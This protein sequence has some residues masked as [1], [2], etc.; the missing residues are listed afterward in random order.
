MATLV[1]CSLRGPSL[2][3]RAY[4]LTCETVHHML[5]AVA[6]MMG[7]TDITRC[8]QDGRHP[9]QA[10]TRND[11]FSHFVIMNVLI[12]AGIL[13]RKPTPRKSFAVMPNKK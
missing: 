6:Y 2:I 11:A 9:T 3:G 13:I 10:T 8:S 1:T 7:L 12:F 4:L 5:F